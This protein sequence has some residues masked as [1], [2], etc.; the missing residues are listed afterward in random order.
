MKAVKVHK[1]GGPEVLTFENAP[2]P[3]PGKGQ[4]L[5]EVHAAG[6][7]PI[8]IKTIRADSYYEHAEDSPTPGF[9]VAGTVVGM[10]TNVNHVQLGDHVYGQAAVQKKGTG[11]FAEYAVTSKDYIAKMPDNISFT[12]AAAVPLAACSAYQAIVEHMRLEPGHKILIHGG[13]GGI[14]TFAVQL[15]K[16]IGAYVATTA[17]GKGIEY[18][19]RLGADEVIDYANEAFEKKLK[20]FDAVLD[21]VGGDTNRKSYQVLKEGGLIVSMVAIP[22]QPLMKKYNVRAV[23]EMTILDSKKLG[24]ITD[25]IK[26]GVLKVNLADTFPLDQTKEALETMEQKQVLGKIA[27]EVKK[28]FA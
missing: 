10:G 1:L 8:D 4:V 12:E 9:D 17:T 26:T 3:E 25:L 20:N 19:K 18:S 16:H 15:A 23:I 27:V 2:I 11:A 13:S 22:D 24:K 21:T 7:N 14:G 28:S 6:V 5:I